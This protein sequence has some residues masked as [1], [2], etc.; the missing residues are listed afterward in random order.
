M[1]KCEQEEFEEAL[2][3]LREAGVNAMVCNAPVAV[4]MSGVKCGR[5]IDRRLS[6]DTQGAGRSLS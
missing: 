6:A 3:M 4:S 1:S 5:R 2:A